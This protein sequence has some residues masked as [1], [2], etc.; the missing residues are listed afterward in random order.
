M[1]KMLQPLLLACCMICASVTSFAQLPDGSVAPDFTLT[2]IDG[3]PHN[4]YSYLA[5][6]K[7]VVLD[8]SATWCGPCWN[9]HNTGALEDLY[10]EHGPDAADDFMVIMIEADLDTELE[11][12]WDGP[13]CTGGTQGNWVAGT[14]YPIIEMTSQSTYT[15]FAISY[16]PTIYTVCPD[17]Y[18]YESGQVPTATHVTWKQSCLF[19]LEFDNASGM[20]CYEDQSGTVNIS[21]IAGAGNITYQ[22]NT[23]QN[24]QDITNLFPGTYRVTATEGNGVKKVLTDMVVDGPSSELMATLGNMSDVSCHGAG[25]GMID[26]N[27]TGGTPGYTWQWNNGSATEDVTGLD[28]GSY[29]LMVIDANNC[30]K[31]ITV[32]I[33]DPEAISATIETTEENCDRRDATITAAGVGGTGALTY[34]Y[35]PSTNQTGVFTNVDGGTYDLVITDGNACVYSET[36]TVD[37]IPAPEVEIFPV[38]PLDCQ[39]TVVQLGASTSVGSDFSYVW[40][41]IDGHI[42]SGQNSLTPDVDAPGTYKLVVVNTLNGCFGEASVT[43]EGS[44]DLPSIEFEAVDAFG[45]ATTEL[46]IDASNSSSGADYT[47]EWT[48]ENGEIIS[49]AATTQLVVGGPGIYTLMVTNTVSECS[50]TSSIEVEG[51]ADL[52]TAL[53]D[54]SSAI[55]CDHLTVTL[56]GEGSSQGD[57]YEYEWSTTDGIIQSAAD[58]QATA[59]AAGTYTLTVVNTLTGCSS[60]VDV[61][62][63]DLSEDVEALWVYTAAGLNVTIQNLTIGQPNTIQWDMG[64]GE[65]ITGDISNYVYSEPG[66]YE[67]CMVAENGCGADDYC[68]RVIV[69]DK[70]RQYADGNISSVKLGDAPDAGNFDGDVD[71]DLNVSTTQTVSELTIYPN[72]TTGSFSIN[73]EDVKLV[74]SYMVVA[75]DGSVVLNTPVNKET[76]R[77]AVNS[78]QIM[79]GT[80]FIYVQ[81]EDEVLVKPLVIIK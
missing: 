22:W 66:I 56:S 23:G 72:P 71:A 30:S 16:F 81:L 5:Q 24:T 76:S 32:D 34:T 61:V 58:D 74:E 2:D 11:C 50:N 43:V 80:Y 62:V 9:Y 37:E 40:T 59:G 57:E 41:T 64:N 21:S 36:I 60:E 67:V 69:S 54:V 19:D 70:I 63:E 68:L 20:Q 51:S 47:Y 48:T 28:G 10:N 44:T 65:I 27:T 39:T 31:E 26:I 42:V 3:N 29:N 78:N 4:L 13:G 79:D 1:K 15:D 35:G 55:D 18:I 12:L 73:L 6:G 49:G 8:F 77:I 45:C 52:P 46:T 17:G 53:V 33:I 75:M 25:D 38:D 7:T 14:P